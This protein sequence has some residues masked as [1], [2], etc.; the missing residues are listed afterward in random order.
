MTL[1]PPRPRGMKGR[2]R[3]LATLV[4]MVS[5][6]APTRLALVGPGGSGKSML[7][8]ALGYGLLHRFAQI[9]W[10]RT[11]AWD[12]RTVA[13]M[14]A[15]RFG[16]PREREALVP[17]LRR[18]L[19]REEH[20]I[21]L[22]NHEDDRA[23]S[24]LLQ[25]LA[26]TRATFILTA[27]RCLL[28]G[29]LV[30]PVTAPLVTT[31]RNAFPRVGALTRL[32]RWNPLAL[33][34]AN[35]IVETGAASVAELTAYL[36]SHGVGVVAVMEHEDDLPEVALLVGWAWQHLAPASR[37]VLAVLAS[38]EGDHVD[39]DSL[40]RLA[41]L[42]ASEGEACARALAA[43]TA[44]H[45]VQ[46]PFSGRY[47][48]HAVVRHAVRKRA[49]VPLRRVFEHYVAMLEQHPERIDLEQTHLFAAMD[50]AHREGDLA[51][52]L[53]IEEL[54]LHLEEGQGT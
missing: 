12:F 48:L 44:W 28:S 25:E 30:Y 40:A 14:L 13:E 27:R 32:L 20:L 3:E 29:V 15:L 19:S 36:T 18:W 41:R 52:M 49:T 2:A 23:M 1:F 45:L 51:G 37:R 38:V 17:G 42:G 50:F 34:I 5:A 35:A 33:D 6:A 4:K 53:R 46:E 16:T 24:R 54:L 8:A 22:D 26:N 9:H 7:A 47:T 39:R 11:A 21:V 10:F 31:G 43:L